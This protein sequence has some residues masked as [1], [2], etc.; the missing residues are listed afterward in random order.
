L[1]PLANYPGDD[2]LELTSAE[3]K[4]RPRDYAFTRKV[5]ATATAGAHRAR[6]T[7][8]SS[9]GYSI[10][11]VYLTDVKRIDPPA[12]NTAQS[13]AAIPAPVPTLAS[14][15]TV[16]H[17]AAPKN[18]DA[19]DVLRTQLKDGVKVVAVPQLFPTP[20]ELAR[21]MVEIADIGDWENTLEPSAGTGRIL[22]A[23]RELGDSWCRR[24]AVELNYNLCDELR[25]LDPGADVVNA[26]FLEYAPTERFDKIVMNPPFEKGADIKHILHAVELLAP[27]GRIVALCAGGPRQYDTLRPLVERH[28]G[29]WERLPE[30]SFEQEGTGVSV[31]LLSF[32]TPNEAAVSSDVACHDQLNIFG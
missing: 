10:K 1:T 17:A 31:V 26:D 4:R 14:V 28:E 2:F 30:G 12:P 5:A 25:K 8:S 9:G 16:A 21:R 6:F 27:G 19:F 15:R 11:Q 13:K 3:F 29:L 20:V 23:I 18:G 24:T 32:A 7:L 22:N